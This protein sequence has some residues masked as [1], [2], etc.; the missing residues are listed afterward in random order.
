MFAI[1]DAWVWDFWFARTGTIWHMFF[2]RAPKSLGDPELRHW[3]VSVGHATSEN[4]VDWTDH[5][6]CFAPPETPG[7]ND[8]TT[9][10]GSVVEGDDGL[11]HLFYTASNRAEQGLKQRIGHAT[12]PDLHRW[13]RQGNG[14]ALDIDTRYYEE[15]RPD[16]WHDRAMRD[17]WVMRDP[18]G[19]G[20][21][22]YFTGRTPVS[23]EA[24]ACGAIGLAR[25]ADLRNWTCAPPVFTG[26]FGQLE[27]PQ[28][29]R[30]DG[31]WYCLFSTAG[32]HWSAAQIA[33]YP[34]HPVTGTHYLMADAPLGPWRPAPGPFL[35]GWEPAELYSGKIVEHQGRWVFLG[36]LDADRDGGFIGKISDPIP[37]AV[38]PDGTLGLV[39]ET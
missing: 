24:N 21:L 34:G 12:S 5:G 19:D 22:M 4:L 25:S 27:V 18:D 36:F 14:P 11:W 38:Q 32:A 8:Y 37:V 35:M 26:T 30:I 7:W 39:R 1:D 17:P 33:G 29:F 28:V 10:T 2:L 31:R 15:Y 13:T 6:V 23:E 16:F 9:W 3:N 20:W